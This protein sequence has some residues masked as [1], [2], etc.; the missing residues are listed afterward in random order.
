[1]AWP[2]LSYPTRANTAGML[3]I[4]LQQ[5]SRE[6]PLA[7][8]RCESYNDEPAGMYLMNKIDAIRHH[9][10]HELAIIRVMLSTAVK[11]APS[12]P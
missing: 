4:G 10:M 11:T 2:K 8:V 12:G 3:R 1:M 7:T 5:C 6:Q 9:K